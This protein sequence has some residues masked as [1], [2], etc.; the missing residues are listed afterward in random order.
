MTSS[1]IS[2]SAATG[3]GASERPDA[4]SID[5]FRALSPEAKAARRA[6][7]AAM[8]PEDDQQS[9]DDGPGPAISVDA[10][11]ALSPAAKAARAAE[12]DGWEKRQTAVK[13]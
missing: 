9:Y 8:P 4:I 3:R 7:I 6:A 13:R 11:R 5:A 2:T 12:F 1:H 10:W